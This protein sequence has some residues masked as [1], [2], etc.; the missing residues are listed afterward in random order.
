LAEAF[1]SLDSYD[2]GFSN[3]CS[4]DRRSSVIFL[5]THPQIHLTS[6]Q[7]FNL[8][9]PVLRFQAAAAENGNIS[10]H[11]ATCTIPA[12]QGTPMF[13]NVCGQPERSDNES[14]SFVQ[15]R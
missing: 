6:L 9:R 13:C 11:P 5:I 8:I 1:T 12:Q 3:V 4:L 2:E 7:D 10:S 14:T 15:A